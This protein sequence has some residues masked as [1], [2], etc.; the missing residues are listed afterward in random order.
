[1]FMTVPPMVVV[2]RIRV[3]VPPVHVQVDPHLATPRAEIDDDEDTVTRGDV[4][5]DFLANAGNNSYRIG[6]VSGKVHILTHSGEIHV[7]GAGSGAELKT[8]GGDIQVGPV[9]GDLKAQ[10][11]AGDIVAKSV[12]GAVV[13][14]TSGG[15]IRVERAGASAEARTAGGD[16]LLRGVG[17]GVVAESGGGE[18]QIV[19]LAREPKNGVRVHNSGGDVTLTVPANFKG[20]FDLAASN[21][22]SDE[23]AIRSDFPEIT[24]TRRSG[25]QQGTGTLNGGGPRVVIRTSSGSIRI[26]R[27]PPAS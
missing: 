3:N 7:A 20:E 27:G 19:L 10:T 17:G 11:L 13:V 22:D 25:S 12:S 26:R 4:T 18:I 23:T 15:D 21:V 16:I 6:R 2:P 14:Q 24:V 9:T 1:M 5:G 8:Y